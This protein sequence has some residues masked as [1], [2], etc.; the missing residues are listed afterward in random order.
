MKP[1]WRDRCT[2]WM[3]FFQH[4]HPCR[5]KVLDFQWL[6]LLPHIRKSVWVRFPTL[7]GSWAEESWLS[8][9]MGVRSVDPPMAV[10][11]GHSMVQMEETFPYFPSY[12]AE[13]RQHWV[14]LGGE[15]EHTYPFMQ[16]YAIDLLKYLHEPMST[17]LQTHNRNTHAQIHFKWFKNVQPKTK[18]RDLCLRS[19]I[20]GKMP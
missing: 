3:D 16:S 6:G 20:S 11:R 17:D 10:S 2:F 8:S 15:R 14:V 1:E 4:L 19:S 9:G 5:F 18:V 12:L 7:R 13:S